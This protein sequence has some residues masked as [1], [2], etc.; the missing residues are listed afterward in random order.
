[1]VLNIKQLSLMYVMPILIRVKEIKMKNKKILKSIIIILILIE[2]I[3]L[4]LLYRPNNNKELL[5]NVKAKE[6]LK[7]SEH[8]LA[9]KVQDEN[10]YEYEDAG[11]NTEWPSPTTHYYYGTSCVD[12]TGQDLGNTKQIVEF[13]DTTNTATITTKK[14]V[15]CTIYFAYKKDAL[16]LM[17]KT[18]TD[19]NLLKKKDTNDKLIRYIGT[20]SQIKNNYICFG[21]SNIS[22]CTSDKDKYMYRIIGIQEQDDDLVEL[23]ANQLKIIKAT[24]VKESSSVKA[25]AWATNFSSDI[26][27]DNASNTVRP[28]L[29]TTFLSTID[30]AWKGIISNPKWYIG[31]DKQATSTT[32]ITNEKK[33]QTTGNYQVGLMYASD[34]YNSWSYG[35]N[36][37]SWLHIIRGTSSSS[38]YSSQ[39]EWTMTRY[40][41]D[42]Y[43]YLAWNVYTGGTLDHDIVDLTRAVRPVFYL[44]SNIKLSGEGTETSPFI[45]TTKSNN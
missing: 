36:T 27:W 31:D 8:S 15:Y 40:G 43:Y 23:K 10:T 42:G 22:T 44:S 5:E 7:N 39:Y 21:T 29:N 4:Y 25:I 17:K 41:R 1:M 9:I 35:S 13:D 11:T 19:S 2:G 33:K 30:T 32:G 20:Y 34:Y 16:D 18:T 6:V 45:I 38:T 3:S 12:E 24:P 37:N 26:D 14:T 28:Y